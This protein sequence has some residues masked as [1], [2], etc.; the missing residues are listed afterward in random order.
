MYKK[1]FQSSTSSPN[2]IQSLPGLAILGKRQVRDL[3]IVSEP[4]STLIDD[5]GWHVFRFEE[6]VQ[7]FK[8]YSSTWSVVSY[9]QDVPGATK[10]ST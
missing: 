9:D 8:Q 5:I 1:G 7:T 10:P 3:W 2:A 6:E 4:T